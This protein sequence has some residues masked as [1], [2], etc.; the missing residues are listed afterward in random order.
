MGWYGTYNETGTHEQI[1]REIMRSYWT[2]GEQGVGDFIEHV[3]CKLVNFSH[4][5]HIIKVNGKPVEIGVTL[6]QRYR[7]SDSKPAEWMYKPLSESMGP[8]AVDCPLD[9][10]AKV[11]PIEG[12]LTKDG[13]AKWS[14][15]WRNSVR[16]YHSR[17]AVVKGIKRGDFMTTTMYDGQELEV[18]YMQKR[19]PVYR[20][21]KDGRLYIMPRNRI[22][23]VRRG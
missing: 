8:C 14:H 12:D 15:D 13:L 9:M 11:P 19:T 21:P 20:S 17:K 5:Y 18:Q 2:G 4:H 6:I 7:E 23:S 10:L 3:D 16:E 1:D 22:T